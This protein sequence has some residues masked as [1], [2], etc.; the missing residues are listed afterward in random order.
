MAR[1]YLGGAI[2]TET[3]DLTDK[4]VIVTGAT[5]GLG[6]ETAKALYAMGATVIVPCR[7][8][9]KGE[10]VVK[11]IQSQVKSGGKIELMSMDLSSLSS[12]A[13]FA[14]SFKA[15]Y[16]SLHILVNN[17]GVWPHTHRETKDSLQEIFQV[18]HLANHLLVGLL[19]PCLK[20]GGEIGHPARVVTLSSAL[21]YRGKLLWD[22][23][24]AGR[25]MPNVGYQSLQAYANSKLLNVLFAAELQRCATR[26][27]LALACDLC[28]HTRSA[29]CL[30]CLHCPLSRSNS[31]ISG[32]ALADSQS[33][34]QL[35]HECTHSHGA[36]GWTE[37]PGTRA[38]W[39][40]QACTPA[41]S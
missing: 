41:S 33:R 13:T 34:H 9:E 6:V 35:S 21:H 22:E 18:N 32:D 26:F 11:K 2:C 40:P 16:K 25:A 23:I 39:L 10:N 12:V 17:A 15:K 19:L 37:T 3:A 31:A 28:H 5:E 4:V 7:N 36:A 14:D 20:A 1:R 29:R 24:E 30:H 8:M 27:R 38:A